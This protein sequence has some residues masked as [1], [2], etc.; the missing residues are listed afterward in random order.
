MSS[1]VQDTNKASSASQ[2]T[3]YSFFYRYAL[4]VK[5]EIPEFTNYLKNKLSDHGFRIHQI[6][7]E[8][9]KQM[10]MLSNTD[11]KRILLEAQHR[12]IRRK[13]VNAF[14]NDT[15]LPEKLREQESR[16]PYS[17][18]DRDKF[19]PDKHFDT[20][21]SHANKK[22]D[23]RWGLGLFSE[24]EMLYLEKMILTEIV[25]DVDEFLGISKNSKFFNNADVTKK[26]GEKLCLDDLTLFLSKEKR[27]FFIY[28]HFG[29]FED[30]FPL[31]VS[32]FKETI[33]HEIIYGLK[34]SQHNVRNYFGDKVAIYF[35]WL[36][37]YSGK[38]FLILRMA[39]NSGD[40]LHFL[41]HFVICIRK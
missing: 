29:L 41:L 34:F 8:D 14:S 1:K 22:N 26:D 12:K 24:S 11:E 25:I 33:S 37:N 30:F 3:E 40:F 28:E 13:V 31:H 32:N 7:L 27:M 15:N 17:Y 4:I 38:I 2:R 39:A 10:L 18:F 23:E 16:R 6:D 19:I 20:F 5:K 9:N 21:Y 35:Y 36:N